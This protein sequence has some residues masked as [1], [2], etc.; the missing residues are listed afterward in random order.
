L[1]DV[2][3]LLS[4]LATNS[5]NGKVQGLN[6]LQGQYVRRYGPGD[7][8]PNVSVQYW[9]MRLMAYSAGVLFLVS[10]WGLWLL[11]RKRLTTSKWFLRAA[12]WAAVLPF[13]INTAGWL[14]TENGR[15]SWIVQGIQLTKNGV[16]PSVGTA[17]VAFS[18]VLFFALCAALAVIDLILM[19][20]Y[21]RSE[22]SPMPGGEDDESA[23]VPAMTY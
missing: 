8:V 9:A 20:N 7:Y 12:V 23:G 3:N 5:W 15:Q 21:A 11:R 2:G 16:S 18:V 6:D 14:L 22:I 10:V 4:L 19:R 17:E 1:V 13:L